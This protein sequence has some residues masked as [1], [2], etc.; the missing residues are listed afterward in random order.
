MQLLSDGGVMLLEHWRSV[1]VLTAT[2]LGLGTWGVSL[3]PGIAKHR[4]WITFP[5][6]LG[7]GAILLTLLSFI[8]FLA[9]LVCRDV[10]QPGA[11]GI[12]AAGSIFLVLGIRRRETLLATVW[13]V[14][15]LLLLLLVRLAFVNQLV[16]P[17]YSDSPTHY[18]V[19]LNLLEPSSRPE[20][21]YSLESI[22]QHYY[23]FGVHCLTAWLA[24]ASG[25]T[26]PLLLAVVG[27]VFLAVLPFSVFALAGILTANSPPGVRNSA[28]WMAGLIAAFGFWMPAFGV[29]WGK[30]P[31]VAALAVT[32]IPLAYLYAAKDA[33][34]K[35]SSGI[36]TALLSAGVILLHSRTGLLLGLALASDVFVRLVHPRLSR[37]R[38]GP[39]WAGIVLAAA[40]VYWGWV[41]PD[42][43]GYYISNWPL[44]VAIAVLVPSAVAAYPKEGLVAFLMFAGM[45]ALSMLGT[46]SFLPGRTFEVLDR[47]FVQMGLYM[48]LA[49]LGGLGAA[50]SAAQLSGT[51][52]LS[53]LPVVLLSLLILLE[54]ASIR[55]FY[56]NQCCDYVSKDDL[57]AF[58]WLNKNASSD[59]LIVTAGLQGSTR[60]LEQDAGAWVYAMTGRLTT[61]RSF[62]SSP[63]DPG[64]LASICQNRKEVYL[65]VGGRDMSFESSDILADTADYVVV[66]HSGSTLLAQVKSCPQ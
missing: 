33:E 20:A 17:P 8:L 22:F 7:T 10:L 59:A 38:C 44:L 27:Q 28:A 30:Y 23:H 61:K 25:E 29:N 62:N 14:P 53:A 13:G 16:L 46:A 64:F 43:V 58:E 51:R 35:S 42:L 49:V 65:Y 9:S 31:T 41:R 39:I 5:L 34:P 2:M 12:L 55:T 26:S 4:L 60:I 6:G 52:R 56:P 36:A 40:L 47:P 45:A 48:P 37:A 11:Y 50:G 3:L 19:V 32:P 57:R 54:A 66:F 63:Y 21:L 18:L 1:L 15:V 24:L